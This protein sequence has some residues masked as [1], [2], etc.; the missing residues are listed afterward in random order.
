[1][2]TNPPDRL[3]RLKTVLDR[4]GLSRSTMY[5]KMDAGTFPKS[6]RISARCVGWRESAVEEWMRHPMFYEAADHLPE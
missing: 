6:V 2:H 1:M 4:T 3:L 5:Q